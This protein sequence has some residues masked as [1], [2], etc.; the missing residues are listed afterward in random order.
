MIGAGAAGITL[1]RALAG[2]GLAICLVESGGLDYEPATQDLAAG[3]NAGHPYYELAD[4][5]LRFFGG[6]TAIWGGR[7]SQLD[8]LDFEARPWVPLSG[9]PLSRADLSP[10]YAVAARD[11]ELGEALGDAGRWDDPAAA[12]CGLDPALLIARRWRFDDL[13]ERFSAARCEDLFRARDVRVVLHANVVH[14]Q[15]GAAARSLDSAELSTLDGRRCRLTARR[16]VLA[17]GGIEN[18][19]LLLAAD[20]VERCGIG[21]RYDQVGRC[22]MEH[23][24]GRVAVLPARAGFALWD[25]FQ[26]SGDG[27]ANCDTA[28]VLLPS[29][30]L[31]RQRG[32]LNSALTF[33]LRRNAELGLPLGRRLYDELKHGLDPTRRGRALWHGY[34][35]ARRT[36]QRSLRRP[37][38]RRRHAAGTTRVH[39]M[40]RGE[41][42]P[43][44]DSRVRLGDERDALG[45]RRAVLDW[46]L[47]SLDKHSVA[48]LAEVLGDELER[49]GIGRP[50]AS[51]WLREDDPAWPLDPTVGNHP[52]GGY[53][54]IGTTRM[55]ADP[56]R[57]VVDRDCRVHGYDNLYVAGSS[58]FTT[59]SWANPTLTIVALAHRLAD[60]LLTQAL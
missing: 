17:C 30:E 58:V 24:H 51:A 48:V 11:F 2:H 41:Q 23:P 28:P 57:G 20:D 15:A 55:S 6:T 52:I 4:A 45:V 56:R 38:A 60:H 21:N 25:A 47:S 29:P 3:A 31:Q 13:A 7:C 16:Y 49:L 44:P 1:A 46:R 36:L 37:L 33:K 34:R 42:A 50:E 9:W 5:R 43:N 14:L 32:I 8:A 26:R 40:V 12:A 18:A 59:S 39:V 27:G 54:H 22:F 35:A 53:H 10:W 19:R